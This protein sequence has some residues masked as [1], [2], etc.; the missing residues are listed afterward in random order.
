[1][2]Q[3]LTVQEPQL[4]VAPLPS[5]LPL[6]AIG[7]E[8]FPVAQQ[9]LIRICEHHVAEQ[10]SLAAELRESI[11]IAKRNKWRAS[12]YDRALRMADR[13][14]L[15]YQRVISALREGYMVMPNLNAD[16]FA[17]RTKRPDAVPQSNESTWRHPEPNPV[18]PDRNLP[19]GEGVYV[20]D[21]PVVEISSYAVPAA[22]GK[23]PKTTY[24]TVP[25]D[26]QS[27]EMPLILAR[28]V[29]LEAAQRAM[30]LRV[31]DEIGLVGANRRSRRADPMLVGRLHDPRGKGRMLTFFLAWFLDERSL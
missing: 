12:G 19:V 1:M 14:V 24:S 8:D 27:P 21:V 3:A 2:E 18:A 10:S 6:V 9:R 15:Y 30:A 13:R 25:V 7:R 28:P 26:T 29:L 20:S 16:V 5:P 17:V 4:P 11:A 22:D 31:F 23:P